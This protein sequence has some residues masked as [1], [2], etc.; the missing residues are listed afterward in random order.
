MTFATSLVEEQKQPPLEVSQ[1]HGPTSAST[2]TE[3]SAVANEATNLRAVPA[4]GPSEATCPRNPRHHLATLPTGVV[5]P[6]DRSHDPTPGCQ[7]RSSCI[8]YQLIQRFL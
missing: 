7:S 8:G 2:A 6:A 1:E 5:H 3:P 4:T